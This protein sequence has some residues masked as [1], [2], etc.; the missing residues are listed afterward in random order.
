M[1]RVD[2]RAL[3]ESL[4]RLEELGEDVPLIQSLQQAVDASV[5]LFDVDGGGLMLADE[6][7]L[8]RYVVSTDGPGRLLEQTQLDANSGPCVSAFVENELVTTGDVAGDERWP[9]LAPRIAGTGV[10]AVLGVPTRLGGICVGS[11]NVYRS[12]VHEWDESEQRAL[13]RYG[14]VVSTMMATAVRAHQAGELA[15]QLGYALEYRVMIERGIGYL[16]ARDKVDPVDAFGR[17]RSA[18]RNNRRKIGDMA[19]EL[20]RTGRLP[21]ER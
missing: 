19:D 11:L 16:M 10:V 13:A 12:R 14:D 17:L 18:A 20:M 6:Q 3:A 2:A 9:A 5:A 4:N 8:L 7:S 21:G 15:D 1:T